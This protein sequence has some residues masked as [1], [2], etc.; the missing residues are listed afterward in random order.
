[1]SKPAKP[2]K[3]PARKVWHYTPVLP[4]RL[5]PY[6]DWPMRP[7]ASLLYLLKSWNPVAMRF[8]ILLAAIATWLWFTPD[9][10]RAK[11]VEFGWVFEVWLRNLVILT[12]VAGGLHL[13]LLRYRLQGD[14]YRYDLRPMARGAKVF[15]FKNQVYDNMF[16]SFVALQFWTFWECLMWWSYANGWARMITFEGDPVWFVALIVLVPIWAGFHFYWLHRLLHVGRLY[17]WVH[18]WHHKNINTGPW[19]G[20]AMHPVESFFLMFDTMIF[21]IVPA[22]PVHVLFLLFHHGI[23]APTSHAGFERLKIGGR[24]GI[25][26]GDFFHQ[27][28]HKFFDC[29][30]GTWETPWDSWFRTFHDGTSEGDARIKQRR[31]QLWTKS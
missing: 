13:F 11:T 23:G 21:F 22:H 24:D 29:N 28:H 6:W 10:E 4:L 18:A 5:A 15:S 9:I 16:W 12:G 14:D 7:L 2:A 8:V 27:L 19:S 26:L 31:M 25:E 30:Y 17:I 3:R 1:M 20:L